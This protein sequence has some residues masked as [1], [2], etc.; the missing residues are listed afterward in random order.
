MEIL[1]NEI[2]FYMKQNILNNENRIITIF[3]YD[4]EKNT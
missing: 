4:K 1:K 3:K 2:S